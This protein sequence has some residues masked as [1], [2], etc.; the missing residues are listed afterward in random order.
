MT[1]YKQYFALER[2][3]N[4]INGRINRVE[5]IQ[6]MT[7]QEK[8]SLKEL[9]P[10]EYKILV[11]GLVQ[12]KGNIWSE[13]EQR[14]DRQ[15]KKIIANLRKLG[16]TLDDGRSDM[17]RIEEWVIKYGYLHKPMNSYD[18]NELPMLVTQVD[19]MLEKFIQKL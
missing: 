13:K 10:H 16:Y 19:K 8:S 1:N 15:R 9:T 3:I 17:R 4:K 6:N 2:E 5:L 11:N 12:V 18:E 14:K 7:N